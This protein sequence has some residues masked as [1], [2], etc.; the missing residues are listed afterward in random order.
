M[1]HADLTLSESSK[2]RMVGW[3]EADHPYSQG[4]VDEA[5]FRKLMELLQDPWQPAVAAGFHSCSLCRFSGGPRHLKWKGIAVE[6]GCLNL[7]LPCENTAFMAPS[8]IVHY[9]DAHSYLPPAEFCEAVRR[10]PPMKSMDYL[11][12]IRKAGIQSSTTE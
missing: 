3:L 7:F 2:L 9:I 1:W 5:T 10:C 6:M 8:L 11:R 4:Q 12:A